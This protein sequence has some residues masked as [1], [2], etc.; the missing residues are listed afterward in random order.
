MIPGTGIMLNNMLGEEDINPRG[1]H[2]WPTNIRLSS[3]MAPTIIEHSNDKISVLGSGGSNRIRTALLQ[4]IINLIDQNMDLNVA[5]KEPRLH[6]ENGVL[7]I[8][9]LEN[10]ALNEKFSS[11]FDSFVP[12]S[13]QNMYF[14][15]VHAVSKSSNGD[16]GLK[17]QAF[18]D[19]RRNGASGLI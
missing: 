1:F 2:Q 8:E 7:N 17:F 18:G 14:G 15:G 6:F 16:L 12:W 10:S 19:L 11:D 4:V 9:A 13:E 3:M 5:I